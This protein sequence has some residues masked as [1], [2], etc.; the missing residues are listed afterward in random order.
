MTDEDDCKGNHRGE[1][2]GKVWQLP[3]IRLSRAEAVAH[4]SLGVPRRAGLETC[5]AYRERQFT[6]EVR[7]R[8]RHALTTNVSAA[9]RRENTEARDEWGAVTF[10]M[11]QASSTS[12]SFAATADTAMYC[13]SA[14]ITLLP[15]VLPTGYTLHIDHTPLDRLRR[16]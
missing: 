7:R 2:H 11:P 6:E 14:A 15:S 5:V 9:K 10:S 16:E 8:R 1:V 3:K 12:H 4:A 13:S